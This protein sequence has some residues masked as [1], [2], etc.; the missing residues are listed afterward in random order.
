MRAGQSVVAILVTLAIPA[1]EEYNIRAK[2]T[3]CIVGAAPAKLSVSEYRS[4]TGQ[5]PPDM[6]VASL[7]SNG[8]TRYCN[9]FTSYAPAVGSFQIDVHEA[10]IHQRCNK[11]SHS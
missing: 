4:T 9:G 1:D 6:N 3:E 7:S 11:Y 10:E 5:W 2:V 8:V